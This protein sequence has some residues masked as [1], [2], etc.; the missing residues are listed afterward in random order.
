MQIWGAEQTT[1]WYAVFLSSLLLQ[2][3]SVSDTR[4]R[5]IGLRCKATLGCSKEQRKTA[6]AHK[7]ILCETQSPFLIMSRYTVLLLSSEKSVVFP[8]ALLYKAF[9]RV[10]FVMLWTAAWTRRA[11]AGYLNEWEG[12]WHS[13]VAATI[14]VH[15]FDPT[16]IASGTA[17]AHN[18]DP[19]A[20]IA[21]AIAISRAD[22]MLPVWKW[23]NIC[24]EI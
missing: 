14:S 17:I 23:A 4:W 18:Q 6:L 7:T 8:P 20:A 13:G 22:S 21:A 19:R 16:T 2:V 24:Q 10:P 9:K 15:I 5:I 3:L 12:L 11:C 1:E